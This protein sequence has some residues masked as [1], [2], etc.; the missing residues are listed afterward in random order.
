M[1]YFILKLIWYIV[2]ILAVLAIPLCFILH[3]DFEKWFA[4]GSISLF[5]SMQL[6][7]VLS[8][9]E[10]KKENDFNKG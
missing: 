9:L 2:D 8:K 6:S 4:V 10:E 5:L 7:L 3:R 1:Y